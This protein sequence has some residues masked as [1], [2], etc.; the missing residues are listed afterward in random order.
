MKTLERILNWIVFAISGFGHALVNNPLTWAMG[1]EK[2]QFSPG[3]K[4]PKSQK[5]VHFYWHNSRWKDMWQ[6]KNCGS[7]GVNID[8]GSHGDPCAVCGERK[9]VKRVGRYY[10]GKWEIKCDK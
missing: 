3:I 9:L 6:C 8:I 1:K 2:R 4:E 7:C 5:A 10:R